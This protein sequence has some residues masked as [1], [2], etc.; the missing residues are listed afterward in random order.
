MGVRKKK[1]QV[2]SIRDKYVKGELA[3]EILKGLAIGGLLVASF[4]LPN[5]P[6]VFHLLG[7]KTARERYRV[8][9]SISDLQKKKMINLYEKGDDLVME[10]TKEGEKR[11][12]KY[13]FDELKIEKPKKWDGFWHLIIFDIPE[14]HKKARNALTRKLK[15]MEFYPFQKSVFIC[16]FECEDEIDFIGE[17]FNVKKFINYFVV[18]EVDDDT[19]LK[20]YY[21]L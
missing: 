19:F 8:K 21:N 3:K 13:R 5:L 14:N 18:K 11:I 17:F 9:R 1:E 10:I 7:V 4:A 16:P 20:R 12:L 15:E 2:K 6:Q